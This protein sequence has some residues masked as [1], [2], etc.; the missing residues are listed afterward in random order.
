MEVP[1]LFV[2]ADWLRSP[3]SAR[4]YDYFLGGYHNVEIDRRAAEQLKAVAPDIV[5]SSR[6]NRLFLRRAVVRLARQ[7]ID[8]FLD[9]GSGIPTVGNV[10]EVALQAN[11]AT[12]V[13]YVDIDP[14]AVAHSRLILEGNPSATALQAD[15]CQMPDILRHPEIL[16]MLDFDRPIGVLL[17]ALLHFVQDEADIQHALRT[18]SRRLP[19]GSCVVISHGAA[20]DVPPDVIEQVARVYARSS[21]PLRLRTRAQIEALF[22]EFELLEPGV[23]PAPVWYPDSS[24]ELGLDNPERVGILVGVGRKP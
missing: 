19:S 14:V 5:L 6:I 16:R 20:D 8:Q 10:H 23:V 11:P 15:F 24:Y 21:S 1:S 2:D 18:L 4:M 22:A 3:N 9:I 12:R 17:V 13:V 7:G